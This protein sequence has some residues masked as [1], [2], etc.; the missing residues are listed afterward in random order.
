MEIPVKLDEEFPIMAL[1]SRRAFI[2]GASVTAGGAGF[3][4]QRR[5]NIILIMA[6]DLSARELG[7]YGHREHR[8]PNLDLLAR[9]G[10]GFRTCWATPICSPSRAAIMTGRYAFRTGWFHND[11]RGNTP[12]AREHLTIGQMMKNAG[13]ATAIT[14]KWQLPG[15][16]DEYGFDEHFMWLEFSDQFTG[17]VEKENHQVPGRTARYWH[18]CMVRNGRLYPTTDRDYGPDLSL[19]FIADFAARH[20]RKLFF[21]YYP[22]VL[23]HGSWDFER[24]RMGHL[25]TPK[26][27][28]TGRRVPGKSEPTFRANVEYVDYQMGELVRILEKLD[29][30]ENTVL[31]FTADNGTA[32]YGKSRVD[33]ERGPRVPLIA[34]CPGLV[35]AIGASDELVDFSDFLPTLA[36]LAGIRLPTGYVI[37]GKSFVPALQGQTDRGREWIFSVYAVHRFL[38]DKRWLL[39]GDGRFYDC[40]DRRD[41]T[42]YMDVTESNAPEVRAA[43]ERFEQILARLPGPPDSLRRR[44]EELVRDQP[45]RRWRPRSRKAK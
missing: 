22:M 3:A 36:E 44:W 43:R 18:P 32:G 34:N 20:R 31:L 7:F 1:I 14:G 6:D 9:T 38:R 19:D 27:D 39:D 16:Y 23:P 30:R 2:T 12:L 24:N 41:E 10:V 15:S 11:L 42:G 4:A 37:D 45:N 29:L 35:K 25:P 33:G 5:P 13:Y 17:P 26:L 21:V 28:P 40:G 8:T